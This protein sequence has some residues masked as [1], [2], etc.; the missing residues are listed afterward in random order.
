[1]AKYI[2]VGSFKKDIVVVHKRAFAYKFAIS[3]LSLSWR[4]PLCTEASDRGQLSLLP[5]QDP[6][7]HL[8]LKGH[9]SEAQAFPRK[10]FCK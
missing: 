10:L 2:L 3:I 9:Q 6:L 7:G 4:V 8:Y 1:M 5:G